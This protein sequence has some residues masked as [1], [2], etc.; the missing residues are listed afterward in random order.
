[1][2]TMPTNNC[3][4]CMNRGGIKYTNGVV[5]CNTLKRRVS[6]GFVCDQYDARPVDAAPG[7]IS[8]AEYGRMKYSPLPL[9][10]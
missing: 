9:A 2:K 10:K 3:K 6:L 5:V 4:S 7:L 1:M 8:S